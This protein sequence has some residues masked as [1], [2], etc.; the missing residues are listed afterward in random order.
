[1]CIAHKLMIFLWQSGHEQRKQENQ[2]TPNP[3]FI[4]HIH[5]TQTNQKL[6]CL[7]RIFTVYIRVISHIRYGSCC[8]CRRRSLFTCTASK[9]HDYNERR[10]NY[11]SLGYNFIWLR[12][13]PRNFLLC[14][15]RSR[16]IFR[17]H[18]WKFSVHLNRNAIETLRPHI[19]SATSTIVKAHRS[20][21]DILKYM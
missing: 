15:F 10:M 21:T 8:C 12:V 6:M 7:L 9:G 18:R 2:S 1:M 16:I 11:S 4:Y 17:F 14:F 19:P 20:S 5:N 13:W 3:K